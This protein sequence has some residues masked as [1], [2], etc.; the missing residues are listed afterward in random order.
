MRILVS[1]DDGVDAPGIRILAE[2]LRDAG[3]EVSVVAP[4]LSL[5]HISEPT[6]RS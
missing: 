4:D 6:R 3:H 5:I 1:N 2:G